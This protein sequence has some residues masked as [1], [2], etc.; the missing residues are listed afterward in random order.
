MTSTTANLERT[1]FKQRLFR[2]RPE[3][4]LPLKIEHQR[5]Y[6]LPTRRGLAYLC[7]LLIMLIASVNYALSLGYA[8]CFLLTGLFAASLLHTYKNVAGIAFAKIYSD[9]VFAGDNVHFKID[10]E[11]AS[12]LD[13]VGIKF[14]SSGVSSVIDIASGESAQAVLIKPTTQRGTQTLGRVTVTST[15]PLGL[16]RTW[17]YVHSSNNAIVYPRPEDSAPPLPSQTV[18]EQG[19]SHRRSTQGDISGIREYHTGDPISS[20][21]WKSAARGQGLF[22]KTFEDENAGGMTHLALTA[23]G[24]ADIEQQLSRM[25]AWVIAAERSQADYSFVLDETQLEATCGAAQKKRA[26]TAL[27]TYGLKP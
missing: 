18:A 19:D 1:S 13:R 22:V 15:Y 17:C 8:L 10:I 4:V 24:L 12:K 7:S 2:S 6:I 25:T 26:L 23:T 5:I 20:I 16:W 21:A 11:N 14:K 3:D 27:A 9:N